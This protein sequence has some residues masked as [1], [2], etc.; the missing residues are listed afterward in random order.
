MCKF[1]DSF[2]TSYTASWP[3]GS[4]VWTRG[5]FVWLFDKLGVQTSLT[6]S[7]PQSEFVM[8]FLQKSCIF[9]MPLSRA[10]SVSQSSFSCFLVLLAGCWE[11]K[12]IFHLWTRKIQSSR[13]VRARAAVIGW[14]QGLKWHGQRLIKCH[15]NVTSLCSKINTMASGHAEFNARD[16]QCDRVANV[17]LVALNTSLTIWVHHQEW[18]INFYSL[19]KF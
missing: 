18:K 8:H 4:G 9:I 12:D 10:L 5:L 13:S 6:Y 19:A 7:N 3:Y 14:A 1:S 17:K 11:N 2:I 15:R 16:G